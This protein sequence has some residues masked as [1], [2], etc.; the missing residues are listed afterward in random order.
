MV[1]GDTAGHVLPAIAIADEY[2]RACADVEVTF[3]AGEAGWAESPAFRCRQLVVRRPVDTA[4][5]GRPDRLCR[6]RDS[7]D[8]HVRDGATGVAASAASC[9]SSA[10]AALPPVAWCSL[11]VALGCR[12]Q[13]WSPTRFPGWRTACSVASP[14][15]LMSCST[16]RRSR[17]RAGRALKTGLPFLESRARL[18]RDRTPPSPNRAARLFIT[19]GS[20]GDAF[21]AADVPPLAARLQRSAYAVEVR[22]QVTSL[23]PGRSGSA[24]L[25][26]AAS[27]RRCF[28][29]VDDVSEHYDWADLVVARAG[30]GTLSELALAGLPSLLVPLA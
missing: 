9:S 2:R 28:P 3:L 26:T 22:H 30:A 24:V 10:P 16:R 20:R 13:S 15:A 27:L 17:F 4:D 19:G 18:M 12:P 7:R 1:V 21:L 29:F 5:A 6:W 14:N 8:P 25:T 11:P 23:D